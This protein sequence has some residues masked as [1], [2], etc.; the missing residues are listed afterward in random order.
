MELSEAEKEDYES[1]KTQMFTRV[2]LVRFVS[3]EDFQGRRL[4]PREP[5]SVFLHMLKRLLDQA[6]PEAD[7]ATRKQLLIHQF[8][9]GLPTHVSRQLRAA[10][11]IDDLDKVLGRA[12]LLLTMKNKGKQP[13]TLMQQYQQK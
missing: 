9:T 12:K 7:T 8:L 3:L 6:M 13:L 1:A 2:A 5:L 11:E 10:G 4:H